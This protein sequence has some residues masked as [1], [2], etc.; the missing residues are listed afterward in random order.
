MLPF[1]V[2]DIGIY[3]HKNTVVLIYNECLVYNMGILNLNEPLLCVRW[4]CPESP[5]RNMLSQV[6]SCGI[7]PT[8]SY[9]SIMHGM[10]AP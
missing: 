2:Q 10:R 6:L 3:V 4:G 9:T 5:L 1:F 8:G 7:T